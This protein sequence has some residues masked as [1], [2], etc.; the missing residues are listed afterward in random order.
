MASQL[1]GA[2]QI[3]IATLDDALLKTQHVHAIVERYASAVRL[4]TETGSFRMQLQRA[5]TPLVG[6][7]KPQFGPVADVVVAFL[8]A[9]SPAEALNR[10]RCGPCVRRSHRC[11][12][13]SRLR[14]Q[15]RRKNTASL[16]TRRPRCSRG[17]ER[18]P[19]L[20]KL[21]QGDAGFGTRF[22]LGDQL[23]EAR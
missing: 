6:L 12:C 19:A 9:A 14:L 18:R 4:Q 21:R 1:D 20:W 13:N 22:E 8:L 15:K 17:Q 3:K 2:G 5:A 10:Q 16:A 23:V 7:L 11:A